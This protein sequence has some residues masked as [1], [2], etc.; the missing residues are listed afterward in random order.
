MD[1]PANLTLRGHH[2]V[3]VGEWLHLSGWLCVFIQ[4]SGRPTLDCERQSYSYFQLPVKA[5]NTAC[6]VEMTLVKW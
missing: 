4:L 5:N 6:C 2:L 3:G 1:I